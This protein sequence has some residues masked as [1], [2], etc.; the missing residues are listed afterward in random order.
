M[1]GETSEKEKIM[2]KKIFG[3]ALAAIFA[4]GSAATAQAPARR[5]AA[6]AVKRGVKRVV[7]H[8][9]VV[10][11]G[12]KVGRAAKTAGKVAR[13]KLE[14]RARARRRRRAYEAFRRRRTGAP[15]RPLTLQE[16]KRIRAYLMA[17]PEMMRVIRSKADLNRDGKLNP[18]ERR[19]FLELL[20]SRMLQLRARSAG[21]GPGKRFLENHPKAV[22][23]VKKRLDRNGDGRVGPVERRMAARRAARRVVRR[24]LDRNHDG[25][26]GPVERRR[27]ARRVVRRRLDRNH[28]GRV[29]PVER[30]RAARRAVRRGVR[31]RRRR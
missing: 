3:L 13:R 26:V 30:R 4:A 15:R 18:M 21:E 9:P 27:A 31:R 29:G 23:R 7:K 16:K 14:G 28:D 12:K 17:H 2:E 22:Q 5:K 24:R 6:R 10:V 19:R 8:H 20:R 11:A 25:R 1:M